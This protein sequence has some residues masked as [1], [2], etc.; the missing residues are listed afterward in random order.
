[1][2]ATF[3]IAPATIAPRAPLPPLRLPM[4][5]AG[6]RHAD[7][8]VGRLM[9]GVDL[10]LSDDVLVDTAIAVLRGAHVDHVVTRGHDGRCTGLLTST[11]LR[12][13]GGLLWYR[14][15]TAVRDVVHDG[16][17]YAL[18]DMPAGAARTAMSERGLTAWPVVDADGY[19]IGVLARD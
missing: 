19:L 2:T 3:D 6:T 15:G 18:A 10:Q 14:E 13:Y 8:T 11:Q 16:G 4:T 7:G 9:A 5:P 12:P 1:M 17:P